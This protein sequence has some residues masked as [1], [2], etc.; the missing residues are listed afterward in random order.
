MPWFSREKSH[1]IEFSAISNTIGIR[2]TYESF[3]R[4]DG[5]VT[6]HTQ[7]SVKQSTMKNL[8]YYIHTRI[9]CNETYSGRL[10]IFM[11]TIAHDCSRLYLVIIPQR[12]SYTET[13]NGRIHIFMLTIAHE[14]NPIY[15][16]VTMPFRIP[17]ISLNVDHTRYSIYNNHTFCLDWRYVHYSDQRHFKTWTRT[18]SR[19]LFHHH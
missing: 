9:I 16:D 6:F 7:K 17:F 11:L 14:N 5:F 15:T 10:P 12:I 8:K 13:Y 18:N 19:S 1:V 2:H 3:Y 4:G